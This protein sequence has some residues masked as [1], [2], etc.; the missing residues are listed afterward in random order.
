MINDIFMFSPLKRDLTKSYGNQAQAIYDEGCKVFG[1][2]SSKRTDF[3]RQKKLY[4]KNATDENYS[5]WFLCN[6]NLNGLQNGIWQNK[7]TNNAIEEFW[8]ENCYGLKEDNTVRVTFAKTKSNGY[9]FIGLYKPVK[10]EKINLNEPIYIKD[11]KLYGGWI[12]FYERISDTYP[13]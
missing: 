4:S 7:I 9:V 12:K 3:A 2:K 6:S 13:S 1:W 5:V 11:K 10:V 8:G